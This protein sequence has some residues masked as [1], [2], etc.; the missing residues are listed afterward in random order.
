MAMRVL[1][2]RL[3]PV[4]GWIFV[5]WNANWLWWSLGGFLLSVSGYN[6]VEAVTSTLLPAGVCQDAILGRQAEQ[7]GNWLAFGIG[8]IGPCLTAPAFEEVL[9]RGFLL[10]VLLDLVPLRAAI[11]MNALLFALHHN[12][13]PGF[14]PLSFLGLL[15]CFLYAASQ[16]LLVTILVHAMWNVRVLFIGLPW[17][18]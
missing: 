8:C 2:T 5:R 13:I 10:P 14:I 15:W 17:A 1:C 9:Y 11:P 6:A 18:R 7:Q 3:K 12:S 4:S 16:N